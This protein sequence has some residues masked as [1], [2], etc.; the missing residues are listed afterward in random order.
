MRDRV[1]DQ[2]ECGRRFRS[3]SRSN[4]V[5]LKNRH[6]S[7]RVLTEE[8]GDRSP[9]DAAADNANFLSHVV[10]F[11]T[12]LTTSLPGSTAC[13]SLQTAL[14][15]RRARHSTPDEFRATSGAPSRPAG[16]RTGQPRHRN[17]PA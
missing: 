1:V 12:V 2:A 4:R 7:V 8:V 14:P 5:L 10:A 11:L 13:Y 17:R 16:I 6:L 3:C 15:P 9:D